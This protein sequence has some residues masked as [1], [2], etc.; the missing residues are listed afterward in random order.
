MSC[1]ELHVRRKSDV[2]AEKRG[3][4]YYQTHIFLCAGPD[5]CHADEGLAVWE[6]LKKSL[7]ARGLADVPQAKVYRSKVGCFRI[8]TDGP[9]AVVYPEG[10]WYR[11][12]NQAA[13]DRIIEEHLVAGRPVTDLMLAHN[14]HGLSSRQLAPMA[15]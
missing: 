11:M 4:A 7:A 2:M 6:H 3:L 8:C 10:V 12:V 5:C 1:D 13:I 9:I 14:T 15:D